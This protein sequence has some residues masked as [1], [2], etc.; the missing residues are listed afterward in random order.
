[1]LL[2][3]ALLLLVVLAT[4]VTPHETMTTASMTTTMALSVMLIASSSKDCHIS[5]ATLIGC[6]LRLTT[7]VV[8]SSEIYLFW[9]RFSQTIK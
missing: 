2:L 3:L 8:Y 7:V 6:V 1:V 4:L 5:V 9:G